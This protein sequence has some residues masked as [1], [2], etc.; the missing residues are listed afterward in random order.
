MSDGAGLAHLRVAS[1]SGEGVWWSG[2]ARGV[3]WAVCRVDWGSESIDCIGSVTYTVRGTA[4][5]C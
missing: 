3:R 2:T 1:Y 4:V 5:D